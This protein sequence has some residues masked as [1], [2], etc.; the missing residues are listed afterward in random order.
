VIIY[1]TLANQEEVKQEY[2]LESFKEMPRNRF[3]GI[4]LAV[5]HNEF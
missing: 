1:D 4:V 3:E 2:N 5:A